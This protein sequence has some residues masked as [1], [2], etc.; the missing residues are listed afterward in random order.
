MPDKG[1][2]NYDF[3]QEAWVVVN[4]YDC[5][6]QRT[7]MFRPDS[8]TFP[9]KYRHK[10]PCIVKI[11]QKFKRGPEKGERMY[12]DLYI[13]RKHMLLNKTE[14]KIQRK[15]CDGYIVPIMELDTYIG[16]ELR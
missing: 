7:I 10:L 1:T 16:Q 5:Y 2:V 3:G 12:P 11:E 9:K 4:K 8:I 6:V 13:L 15:K 14:Q